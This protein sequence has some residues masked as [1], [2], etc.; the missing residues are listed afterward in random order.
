VTRPVRDY[1]Q[2][3]RD[4]KALIASE[5][6]GE[7]KEALNRNIDMMNSEIMR[8]RD[9]TESIATLEAKVESLEWLVRGVIVVASLELVCGILIALF[10]KSL[11]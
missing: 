3:V 7:R 9:R 5:T 1:S 8:L 6:A 4:L 10:R 11:G 2:T